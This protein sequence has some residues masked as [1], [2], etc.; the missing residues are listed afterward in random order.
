MLATTHDLLDLTAADLMSRDVTA[1]PENM[2]LKGAARLLRNARISGAPVVDAAGRC[3]GVLSAADFLRRAEREDRPVGEP[4]S[5]RGLHSEWE[6]IELEAVP[7]DAV[8]AFMSPDPVTVAPE[9]SICKLARMMLDAHIHRVI[10]VDADNRPVGIVSSTDIF[11]AI[12]RLGT[13]T[14]R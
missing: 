2:S 9:V 12:A 11:A 8:R 1:I 6:V 14:A 4:C 13:V 7:A 5:G 3:I 10:V